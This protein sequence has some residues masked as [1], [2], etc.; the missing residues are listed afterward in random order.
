MPITGAVA[1]TPS[2][3]T[4]GLD[5]KPTQDLIQWACETCDPERTARYQVVHDIIARPDRLTL[6]GRRFSS[7]SSFPRW[8]ALW[9]IE[10]RYVTITG[11]QITKTPNAINFDL[12]GRLHEL[13]LAHNRI[14]SIDHDLLRPN[15]DIDLSHN[16]LRSDSLLPYWRPCCHPDRR[17]DLSHN[18]IEELPPGMLSD[19]RPRRINLDGNPLSRDAWLIYRIYQSRGA[20]HGERWDLYS[21]LQNDP[22]QPGGFRLSVTDL[23]RKYFPSLSFPELLT[24]L[25]SAAPGSVRNLDEFR[26]MACRWE[27]WFQEDPNNERVFDQFV[28]RC[29][30]TQDYADPLSRTLFMDRLAKLFCDMDRYP[31]ERAICLQIADDAVSRCGD[32]VAV[33]INSMEM[34]MAPRRVRACLAVAGRGQP[35]V[36]YD[37]AMFQLGRS[38][39]RQKQVAQLAYPAIQQLENLEQDRQKAF[40]LRLD[41]LRQAGV[42]ESEWPKDDVKEIEEVEIDLHY[43]NVFGEALGL[44]SPNRKQRWGVEIPANLR[45]S[46]KQRDRHVREI[47]TREVQELPE[48]LT[49]WGPW[50]QY[51]EGSCPELFSK[52]DVPGTDGR[53]IPVKVGSIHNYASRFLLA[54]MDVHDIST[55]EF[56]Q[57]CR[58]LTAHTDET[59]AEAMRR[60]T[61]GWISRH[62]TTQPTGLEVRPS[63][64]GKLDAATREDVRTYIDKRFMELAVALQ[65][66]AA[67]GL[68]IGSQ[69]EHMIEEP[70]PTTGSIQVTVRLP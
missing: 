30:D 63:A 5:H 46:T 53:E 39:Y 23:D 26:A 20:H 1:S 28:M 42:P 18:L 10:T 31:E 27:A 32:R 2:Y 7:L 17:L 22:S 67:L 45:L 61:R 58:E 50:Q 48:F 70:I 60:V 8:A 19:P 44:P 59:R 68:A 29:R 40:Q 54:I 24:L 21:V 56:D 33:G 11:T 12:N 38:Y 66:N 16:Q 57:K 25:A 9:L 6:E 37:A 13:N 34:L 36:S 43:Q 51:L 49:T 62:T 52:A 69:T 3:P 15:I 4:Y 64:S 65:L 41:E 55:Q 35:T 47:Q 14:E